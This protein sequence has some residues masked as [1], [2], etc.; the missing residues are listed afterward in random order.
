MYVSFFSLSSIL[1]LSVYIDSILSVYITVNKVPIE[2]K[3]KLNWK[4]VALYSLKIT[5]N[6]EGNK[7]P[8]KRQNHAI[9][10]GL[11]KVLTGCEL[12]W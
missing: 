12:S 4:S 1:S 7:K 10:E 2:L 9:N 5:A 3:I 8:I 11:S 6:I